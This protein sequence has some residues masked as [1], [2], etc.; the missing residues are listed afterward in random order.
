MRIAL[1][2]LTSLLISAPVFAADAP[3]PTLKTS[4]SIETVIEAD[5]AAFSFDVHATGKTLPDAV[6]KGRKNASDIVA[7]LRQ[8]GLEEGD[9][10][11]GSFFTNEE[12]RQGFLSQSREYSINLTI[13]IETAKLA[14]VEP[15]IMTVF[16]MNPASVSGVTFSLHDYEDAKFNALKLAAK[17]ARQKAEMLAE[18]T[19]AKLGRVL[20]VTESAPPGSYRSYA[21][22][23]PFNAVSNPTVEA[24]PS[25]GGTDFADIFSQAMKLS[26]SVEVEY[27][28]LPVEEKGA[29]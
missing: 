10:R 7:A 12:Y 20:K 27:E 5:R 29:K 2:I 16:Q 25:N 19:G 11:I 24:S 8:I 22:P 21:Y 9:I 6:A 3:P 17:K 28:L 23:N 1:P 4:G 13:R 26:A 18:T 14:L 15:A